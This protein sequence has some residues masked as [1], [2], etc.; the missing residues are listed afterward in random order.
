MTDETKPDELL[1]ALAPYIVEAMDKYEV[2]TFK[3]GKLIKLRPSPRDMSVEVIKYRKT[4][5]KINKV[6]RQAKR[7]TNELELSAIVVW[8]MVSLHI[9]TA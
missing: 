3:N 2:T 8:L 1:R 7:E 6:Q 9:Y 4:R 5:K